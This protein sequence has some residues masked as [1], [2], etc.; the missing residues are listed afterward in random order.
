MLFFFLQMIRYAKQIPRTE[1]YCLELKDNVLAARTYSIRRFVN[2]QAFAMPL[3]SERIGSRNG[4][5]F[6]F[7]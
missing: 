7:A 2:S 1:K 4:N 3:G 6:L 5:A